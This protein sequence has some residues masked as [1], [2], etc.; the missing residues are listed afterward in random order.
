MSRH[1]LSGLKM[2]QDDS[3]DGQEVK[4]KKKGKVKRIYPH[5]SPRMNQ[6]F[7]A[8]NLKLKLAPQH[9]TIMELDTKTPPLPVERTVSR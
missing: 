3:D 2:I 5:L 8:A 9:A 1:Y 4:L 6:T 7:Q